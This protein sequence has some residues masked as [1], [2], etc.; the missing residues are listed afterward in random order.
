[1]ILYQNK[2][3]DLQLLTQNEKCP[4]QSLIWVI[5]SGSQAAQSFNIVSAF[6]EL[7]K[8]W[9]SGRILSVIQQIDVIKKIETPGRPL[10]YIHI[11]EG[12]RSLGSELLAPD[13][14]S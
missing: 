10:N 1:M 6:T 12:I 7:A 13:P 3:F 2:Y 14:G 11:L 8:S 5:C 9:F 4:V